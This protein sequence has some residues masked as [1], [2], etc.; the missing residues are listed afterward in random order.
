MSDIENAK[1]ASTASFVTALVFNSALFGIQ[2]GLFTVLRP[3]FKSVYEPLTYVKHARPLVPPRSKSLSSKPSLSQFF[4]W[5]YQLIF[6]S[7]Y[8]AIIKLN[9]LDAYFFVRFLQVF[10]ITL[11]PIWIISWVVLLPITSVNT[12]V[13]PLSGL[14]IFTLGNVETAK[15]AR[16][17]AHIILI[18][19]FTCAS[20][21]LFLVG[22]SN[23]AL[24]SLDLLCHPQ[25]N[26]PLPRHSSTA[27]HRTD[28]RKVG[29]GKHDP[30][31]WNPEAL[32]L[33]G[34]PL[35]IVQRFPRWCEEDLD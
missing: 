4:L 1:S 15:K 24:F 13:P 12:S 19:G 31:H 30:H 7:D 9:G 20:L 26:A 3:Y 10:T 8:R 16:Y 2:L 18:Y 27:P 25:R 21:S 34:S 14:D 6:K 22:R 33:T 28:T 32:S 23:S 17:A 35:Q 11:I 5:P 29:T